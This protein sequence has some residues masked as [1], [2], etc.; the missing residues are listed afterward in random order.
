MVERGAKIATTLDEINRSSSFDSFNTLNLDYYKTN[1]SNTKI[2][3]YKHYLNNN[4]VKVA[5]IVHNS[6]F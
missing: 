6:D 5:I 1:F 4:R 3:D 2:R